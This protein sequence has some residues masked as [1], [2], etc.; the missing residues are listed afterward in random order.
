MPA[1][2]TIFAVLALI[3]ASTPPARAF[4]LPKADASTVR[5]IV[6]AAKGAEGALQAVKCCA[7]G[8]GFVIAE[9]YVATNHHVIDSNN[10][11]E[12]LKQAP[13][14]RVI[15]VV[16]VAGS[17]KNYLAQLVWSSAELDLAVLR[18]LKLDKPPLALAVQSMLEY[19]RRGQRIYAIGYPGISDNLLY[20]EEAKVTST[21]TEA[22][23]ARSRPRR[24]AAKAGRP[25]S[26]T[27]RSIR[28]IRAAR[29]SIVAA[30]S[31]ASIP[32]PRG[33]SWT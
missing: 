5:V 23:S 8:S 17:Q 16:R 27:R 19:P 13:D 6:G 12:A 28:E 25:S 14:A 26:T 20:S 10:F 2:R 7:F 15:Y 29:C 31:S 18:V 4:D 1:T 3:L 21:V 9:D 32:S 22:L 24:W 30:R 33:R 11:A